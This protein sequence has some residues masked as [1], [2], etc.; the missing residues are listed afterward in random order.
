[1][2]DRR[3]L[4]TDSALNQNVDLGFT[5]PSYNIGSALS[6]NSSAYHAFCNENTEEAVR[7]MSKVMAFE[8]RG[9]TF[10]ADVDLFQWN[11]E[12][13]RQIEMVDD[14]EGDLNKA[15]ERLCMSLK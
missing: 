10:Y 14:V 2:E 1:M 8:A 12:L 6:Q 9:Q 15:K 11:R 4:E 7:F 3:E 5:D 13:S